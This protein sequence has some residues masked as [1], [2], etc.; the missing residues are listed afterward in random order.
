MTQIFNPWNLKNAFFFKLQNNLL[1]VSRR[2][3]KDHWREGPKAKNDQYWFSIKN[4]LLSSSSASTMARWKEF[5]RTVRSSN[6]SLIVSFFL[7]CNL[8]RTYFIHTYYTQP[9][10]YWYKFN[11]I[12]TYFFHSNLLYSSLF[13][14]NLLLKQ[15]CHVLTLLFPI[16]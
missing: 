1:S 4:I 10:Y 2:S 5:D 8:I 6:R 14:S 16:A 11:F 13:L 7:N 9:P 15:K 12:I 3:F